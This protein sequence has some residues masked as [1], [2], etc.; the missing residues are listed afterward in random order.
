MSSILIRFTDHKYIESYKTGNLFLSSL[1]SFWDLK[2]GKIPYEKA[3]A[4]TPEELQKAAN[5]MQQ[6]FS[7]GVS[8]QIPRDV[9]KNIFPDDWNNHLIHD[10]RFQ[11]D[12]Y[13]FCNLLCFYRVD[14]ETLSKA[15]GTALLDD[16]YL[17]SAKKNPL[18]N[19]TSHHVVQCPPDNMFEFGDTVILIKDEAEFSRRVVKAIRNR[20]ESC[21]TGDV[22]YHK[23]QDRII[24]ETTG[25]HHISLRSDQPFLNLSDITKGRNDV[26]RYGCLDK[27][28][29]Y[30]E[31]REWRV[32]WLPAEHNHDGKILSVGNLEDIIEIIDAAQLRERL[33][34]LFPGY[35][36]GETN[37][38]RTRS[39]GTVTYGHF[40]QMVE[41]IDGRCRVIFEIG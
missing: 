38:T 7:E 10:V 26:I 1:S 13:G 4:A 36:L 23:M 19:P 21:V 31:Q 14:T 8:A 37:V 28:D 6:D 27:Y 35:Y 16:H 18:L 3:A 25:H 9:V 15:S 41:A 32:C 12:A 11:I 2:K 34:E 22:R 17:G 5:D 29:R 40:K 20:G 30:K 39:S 33:L 24:P